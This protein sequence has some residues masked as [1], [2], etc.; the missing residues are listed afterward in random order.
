MF[1][2]QATLESWL[3]SGSVSM[4]SQVVTLT[5]LGRAYQ[6]ES[7]VRVLTVLSAEGEEALADSLV[8]KILEER[9]ILELG[10]EMMGESMLFGDTAF[11]VEPGFIGALQA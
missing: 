11:E 5:R 6:L 3:D 1:I 4:D 2:S 9:K 10:G 7:A 8:G